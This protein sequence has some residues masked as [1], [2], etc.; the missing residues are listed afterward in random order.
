[1][2]IK[3]AFIHCKNKFLFC[4]TNQCKQ[5][6]QPAFSLNKEFFVEVSLFF[7]CELNKNTLNMSLAKVVLFTLLR[8]L[9]ICSQHPNVLPTFWT[10]QVTYV[11]MVPRVGNET[12]RP[13][14]FGPCFGRKL[15]TKKR[16]MYSPGGPYIMVAPVVTSWA[17]AG[18]RIVFLHMYFQTRVTLRASPIA[19]PRGRSVSFPTRGTMV[20]YVTWDDIFAFSFK[21]QILLIL[22]KSQYNKHKS[23]RKRIVKTDWHC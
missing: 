14:G 20:T 6:I 4:S 10:S 8:Y 12:L 1:M 17:V 15:Q 22:C 5:L 18:Q 7:L 19:T 3:P 9:R 13:L 21:R 23:K 11:T 16:M 2:L